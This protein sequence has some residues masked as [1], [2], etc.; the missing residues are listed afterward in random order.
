MQQVKH[1]LIHFKNV[2]GKNKLEMLSDNGTVVLDMICN[3]HNALQSYTLNENS[4]VLISATTQ[5]YLSLGKLIKFCDEI[6]LSEDDEHGAKLSQENVKE[7][8]ELVESSVNNLVKV[9]NDKIL[10]KET[11]EAAAKE[12]TTTTKT[13]YNTLQRPSIDI[14]G[15]RTSLPDIP[16]T[17]RERDILEK[18]SIVPVRASHSTES[19][20]R[21]VS[22]P[23]K[24]PLPP[25]RDSHLGG[26]VLDYPPP[27]PPKRRSQNYNNRHF[28]FVQSGGESDFLSDDMSI[29]CKSGL[30]E[31]DNS[32]LLSAS[33]GSLDSALN[34]SREE[35]ELKALTVDHSSI[36][37]QI[38]ASDLDPQRM[39]A[40]N[41]GGLTESSSGKWGDE[42]TDMVK[43]MPLASG[44]DQVDRT[45]N[46]HS[47]E[48]GFVSMHSIRSSIQTVSSTKRISS[49]KT[50]IVSTGSGKPIVNTESTSE[51]L[52]ADHHHQS[53][54]VQQ[55]S[56]VSPV[57]S[58]N[59][60]SM[61][62]LLKNSYTEQQ[63]TLQRTI[64]VGKITSSVTDGFLNCLAEDEAF[65][66]C[67][68]EDTP[69][70]L[71]I[72]TRKRESIRERHLST[73]DNV[74]DPEM[75]EKK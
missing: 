43:V 45:S 46:R 39:D 18:S 13:S 17:P 34:H 40:L 75:G 59:M 32:S 30:G 10:E 69:P 48:S 71:P 56:T 28:S 29:G 31:E 5:V 50:S 49:Q 27:L 42:M 25:H 2:V 53:Q 1:A 14:A 66:D 57:K 15:Q 9:A 70:A 16:L 74:D 21:D 7:I 4:S 64:N 58:P 73:Y 61:Q 6:L 52:Q 68:F 26:G 19:I 35:D 22:P 54:V 62:G 63:E 3:V 41:H 23:P 36:D 72:K 60:F 67:I 51:F 8:V 24:P 55:S 44:L 47:N 11:C 37:E 33:A 20:L 12:T 38:M 65:D